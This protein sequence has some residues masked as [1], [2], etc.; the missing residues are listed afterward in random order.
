MAGVLDYF[1]SEDFKEILRQ[2]EES[3]K[4]GERIY[5]DGDDL[6]DIADYYNYHNRTAEAD[7]A[8]A[9]AIEFNPE[10]VG[11]M[12]YKARKAIK[13]KDFKTAEQYAN[14]IQ[15]LDTFEATFLRAEI[16]IANGDVKA[17][18]KLIEQYAKEIPADEYPD[19]LKSVIDFYLDY[20][21]FSMASKWASFNPDIKSDEFKEL[22]ARILFGL[23]KYQA[24]ETLFNELL[25][26]NPYS[27][28]YWNALAGVQYMKKDFSS[29]LTSSEY[30]LAIDPND[31]DSILSKANTLYTMGNYAAAQEYF[32]KYIEMKPDDEL[33][34]LHLGNC[35][36]SQGSDEEGIKVFQKGI[37]VS[38]IDSP[39]LPEIYQEM[40]F[41]YNKLG[42]IDKALMCIDMTEQLNC[43]HISI[44]VTKGHLLLFN[45]REDEAKKVFEHALKESGNDPKTRLK[46]IISY[47]DNKY[48]EHA[49]KAYLDF[50]N[51]VDDSFTEGYAFF[52]LCCND[53]SKNDE[54]LYYLKKA[55]EINPEEAKL[56]LGGFFPEDM[57]PKDYYEYA[58]KHIDD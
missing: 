32:Q 49:Y 54:F 16:L 33:G 52:A 41:A 19:F 23:G 55:C 40:A 9:L 14:K 45:H 43:D 10:A 50:F 4:S 48:L 38:P 47:Q 44:H 7:A 11:P 15:A 27:T 24:S 3:V 25:D 35:I 58:L 28:I 22:S 34:Y 37:S 6:T 51:S 31:A 29:A 1:D 12:L 8:I 21:L 20:N 39:F 53:L 18:D 57:D 2:Y 42:Q 30:A 17:G 56:V 46:I 26:K 5:M 36:I 13:A